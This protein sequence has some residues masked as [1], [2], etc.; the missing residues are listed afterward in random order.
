MFFRQTDTSTAYEVTFTSVEVESGGKLVIQS[1]NKDG[2]TLTGTKVHV[3]SGGEIEA[4]RVNIVV[5]ELQIDQS[6]V[7]QAN[8]KVDHLQPL[9]F[10]LSLHHHFCI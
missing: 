4:D 10:Y 5:E 6:G 8:Y 9:L 2:L 3:H 1:N 7:I